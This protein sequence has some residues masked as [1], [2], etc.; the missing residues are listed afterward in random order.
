MK[1]IARNSRLKKYLTR[2]LCAAFWIAVWQIASDA[3]DMKLFF[4]SPLSVFLRLIDLIPTVSFW[5]TVFFSLSRIG[6]GFFLAFFAAAILAA[7]STRFVLARELLAPLLLTVRSVPVVSFVILA[8]ILFSSGSLATLIVFLMDLPVLYFNTLEGIRQTDRQLLEMARLFRVP[9]LR[10][11]RCVYIPEIY[12]YV[13]S[14]C[15]TALGISWK[16]GTAAEVI[17]V[18]SGS[19]GERLYESKIYLETADLFA[20]TLVIIALSF[21]CEKIFLL[22]LDL[23]THLSGKP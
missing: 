11:L 9:K 12:P 20:W 1:A 6:A 14:A 8:L 16:S 18:A 21:C 17:A 19:I 5:K 15:V 23:F 7:L 10:T 22:L 2:G 4:V 13:R 3:A